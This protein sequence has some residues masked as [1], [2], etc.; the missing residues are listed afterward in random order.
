MF[1]KKVFLIF[2]LKKTTH[3]ESVLE[4]KSHIRMTLNLSAFEDSS[5]GVS[6]KLHAAGDMWHVIIFF[7]KKYI[8][9]WFVG[10]GAP[11]NNFSAS[12]RPD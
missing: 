4:K 1:T 10:I 7:I 3:S 12:K 9:N 2:F 6:D 11:F 5:N 8:F